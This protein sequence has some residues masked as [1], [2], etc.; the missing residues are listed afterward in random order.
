[1]K[2][3]KVNC[4][5]VLA[6]VIAVALAACLFAGVLLM[7]RGERAEPPISASAALS[8]PAEG[9]SSETSVAFDTANL[10]TEA[11]VKTVYLNM[12]GEVVD[13]ED[14][15]CYIMT[16]TKL[17]DREGYALT[18]FE[19][20]EEGSLIGFTLALDEHTLLGD[21]KIIAIANGVFSEEKVQDLVALDLR[22]TSIEIIGANAFSGQTDL[23]KLDLPE[24]LTH[25]GD[26]AFK[27]VGVKT[28][29]MDPALSVIGDGAFDGAKLVVVRG[30]EALNTVGSEAFAN[31]QLKHF[32]LKSAALGDWGQNVF[33]DNVNIRL[34]HNTSVKGWGRCKGLSADGKWVEDEASVKYPLITDDSRILDF[35]DNIA[36]SS[37]TTQDEYGIKYLL[38]NDGSGFKVTVTGYT[39]SGS[40]LVVPGTVIY[41]VTSENPVVSIG[42]N[43]F[44][45]ANFSKLTA[46]STTEGATIAQ[47][48]F[49]GCNALGSAVIGGG[50]ASLGAGAFSNCSAL[51]SIVL[52]KDVKTIAS[53]AFSGSNGIQT[54]FLKAS[55]DGEAKTVLEG[56]ADAGTQVVAT[57]NGNE[58]VPEKFYTN[59]ILDD[60]NTDKQGVFYKVAEW[61]EQQE[62]VAYVGDTI[63][64]DS[65]DERAF[66]S[67]YGGSDAYTNKRGHVLIPDYISVGDTDEYYRVAVIGRYAFFNCASLQTLELGAHVEQ[68]YDCSLRNCHSLEKFI[69]NGRNS[70]F[71]TNGYSQDRAGQTNEGQ[72]LFAVTHVQDKIT[73]DQIKKASANI[74]EIDPA[75]SATYAREVSSVENYAFANCTGLKS[76]NFQAFTALMYIGEH[77]FENTGLGSVDLTY[78]DASGNPIYVGEEAFSNCYF[79][80]NVTIGKN[81]WFQSVKYVKG[82]KQADESEVNTKVPQY[83]NP[84]LHCTA[85]KAFRSNSETYVAVDDTLYLMKGDYVIL[86]QY[87]AGRKV[88]TNGTEVKKID[89]NNVKYNDKFYPIRSIAAYAFSSTVYLN[90]IAVGENVYI[91][92]KA[93]FENCIRLMNV[94]IGKN[95]IYIGMEIPDVSAE[96]IEGK[97]CTSGKR[98][99]DAIKN[100]YEQEVFQ[101]CYVLGNIKVD[102]E[103]QYYASDTNG[104][105]YN[106]D[107]TELM[108]YGQGISRLTFTVPSTVRKISME[109]FQYNTHI[110]RINLPESVEEIGAK[111][112]NG[113]T[114]LSFIYFRTL[115]A[116]KIG[117]QAFNSAG[118]YNGGLHLYC[119]PEKEA[120]IDGS[121]YSALWEPYFENTERFNSIEEIP[122][123]TQPTN[124]VYLVYVIDADGNSLSD[125]HVEY[126]YETD[127]ALSRN[128]TT[129]NEYGYA[130]LSIPYDL[131]PAMLTQLHV[132]DDA[133]VFFE[134]NMEDYYL[135][136]DIGFTYVTLYAVP[137]A[138]GVTM[139]ATD[140]NGALLYNEN[141]ES[142]TATL[143]TAYLGFL[144]PD[145]LWFEQEIFDMKGKS[146]Q[147]T[148]RGSWDSKTNPT[149]AA[150]YRTEAA[151]RANDTSTSVA[152]FEK[153]YFDNNALYTGTHIFTFTIADLKQFQNGSDELWLR[154][155]LEYG[156]SSNGGTEEI[157]LRL[158][159]KIYY[160]TLVDSAKLNFMSGDLG[161]ELKISKDIPF[162]GGMNISIGK[163]KKQKQFIT[164]TEDKIIM[165]VSLGDSDLE[166]GEL[167]DQ[168]KKEV[169]KNNRSEKLDSLKD[170]ATAI[171]Q[172][173]NSKL[174]SLL[175]ESER[176]A[177]IYMNFGGSI[178]LSCKEVET[179]N[180][181][182]VPILRTAINGAI[183]FQFKWHQ[184]WILL[185]IPVTVNVDASAEGNFE[186]TVTYDY[187][188]ERLFTGNGALVNGDSK[189]EFGLKIK[190][191]VSAGVGCSLASVGLYGSAA[192]DL[193]MEIADEF[194]FTKGI[195]TLDIG[196]YL[197]IDLGLFK[198]SKKWSALDWFGVS[199]EINLLKNQNEASYV[200][201]ED[202]QATRG[203]SFATFHD[204]I[205][206]ALSEVGTSSTFQPCDYTDYSLYG[207]VNPEIVT[208]NNITY[209]FYIENVLLN[210]NSGS[211]IKGNYD[212]YNYLKLVYRY[213]KGN[214]WSDYIIVNDNGR[215]DTDF[216]CLADANG[217]HLIVRS[218]GS[219][220]TENTADT[221][222]SD[223]VL[224]GID[225]KGTASQPILTQSNQEQ[226]LYTAK[227]A[228][229][230]VSGY[231]Y[232]M[233][234]FSYGSTI[235][236]AW[237]GNTDNNVFGM[238]NS[239]TTVED[240]HGATEFQATPTTANYLIVKKAQSNT[241]TE[242]GRVTG[243][244]TVTDG[245]LASLNNRAAFLFIT[246]EDCDITTST[247]EEG[248]P[249]RYV[250]VI[251]LD[252][253]F[254]TAA[255]L[256]GYT[257]S[258]ADG[259]VMTDYMGFSFDG[260]NVYLAADGDLYRLSP[261]NGTLSAELYFEGITGNYRFVYDTNGKLYGILTII[262]EDSMTSNLYFAPYD[263]VN[264]S[265][266][267]FVRITGF[268]EGTMVESYSYY[269]GTDGKLVLS[270]IFSASDLSGGSDTVKF[271]AQDE[272][273]DKPND[274]VFVSAVLEHCE[275]SL[276]PTTSAAAE[277]SITVN[278]TFTVTV[279]NDSI[280]TL[281]SF[282]ILLIDANG[283]TAAETSMNEMLYGGATWSGEVTFTL[284][285][286]KLAL[287]DTYTIKVVALDEDFEELTAQQANNVCLDEEGQ[288]V[289]FA[290]ARPDLAVTADFVVIGGIKYVRLMVQNVGSLPVETGIVYA[291]NGILDYEDAL[292]ASQKEH[293]YVL[294][295]NDLAPGTFRYFTVELNRVWFTEQYVTVGT[296]CLSDD[297]LRNE[298]EWSNN[299]ATIEVEKNEVLEY[300]K[301]T[302]TYYVDEKI[303]HQEYYM[304]GETIS[305]IPKEEM[306]K[307]GYTFEGWVGAS[308]IKMPAH[309]IS[310]YGYYVKN[311][312][313]IKYYIN[314]TLTYQ[315]D[316]EYETVADVR[317]YSPQIGYTFTGW[318][319]EPPMGNSVAPGAKIT[320]TNDIDLYGVT[321][322][323]DYTLYFMVNGRAVHTET[324]HYGERIPNYNYRP[325]EGYEFGG[326]SSYP[327]SMPDHDYYIYGTASPKQYQIEYVIEKEN[328]SSDKI[329]R[330]VL[331]GQEANILLYSR[332]EG[333]VY[334]GWYYSCEDTADPNNGKKIA[335][336]NDLQDGTF[337]M[338]AKSFRL[339]AY[340]HAKEFTVFYIV[341]SECVH[342]EKVAY[343]HTIPAYEYTAPSGVKVSE[344]TNFPDDGMMPA[345][346]LIL[347]GSTE[348][349]LFTIT[350]FKDSEEV[351]RQ[352]VAY[353]AS[354]LFLAAPEK[355][356]YTFTGWALENG[357]GEPVTL[358]DGHMPAYSLVARAQYS[359]NRYQIEWIVDGKTVSTS[360]LEYG[361][362]VTS[363]DYTAPEG[364]TFSGWGTVPATMPAE[365][366]S[367]YGSTS[368]TAYHLTYYI[369]GSSV[370][371]F[372]I[373]YGLPTIS[374]DYVA[375]AG[376]TFNGWQ[377][378]LPAE[379]PAHDI[380]IH[381]TTTVNRY[382]IAYYVDGILIDT[383]SYDYRAA[384]QPYVYQAEIGTT[385]LGFAEEPKTMP[386]HNVNVYGRT[387]RTI[388]H[389]T[390][391]LENETVATE[392][393]PYGAQILPLNGFEREGFT[394]SWGG[395]PLVMP[396]HDITVDGEYIANRYNIRYYCDGELL[397]TDQGVYGEQIRLRA[398]ESKEGYTFTGWKTDATVMPAQ[399][400][401]VYGTF[402]A[403]RYRVTF[404]VNGQ[405]YCNE[406]EFNEEIDLNGL[407]IEGVEGWY[408]DGEK[409][410]TLKM[411]SREIT[412]VAETGSASIYRSAWFIALLSAGI[413]TLLL[414][415]LSVGL[416]LMYKKEKNNK[417]E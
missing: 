152:Y 328:G 108:V 159:V 409:V 231:V 217:I 303:H 52:G 17:K 225:L 21:S 352:S 45:G 410:E 411:P 176:D 236:Y 188:A 95:V 279:K 204:S 89:V 68:I 114:S 244:K 82:K 141:I 75:W 326:W 407:G 315:D 417:Y 390:Y 307:E 12:T 295:F 415:A 99:N 331:F 23:A 370:R 139:T 151:A 343:N 40:E 280:T 53:D 339:T 263:A 190:L 249:D 134:Y 344:W 154:L 194:H 247:N 175:L 218:V 299:G 9:S 195:L 70:A 293:L 376:Y 227:G 304:L 367:F 318:G 233:S 333:Y 274:L 147:I 363:Y 19:R 211:Q 59:F 414:S 62:L 266:G 166:M 51:R 73:F 185:W 329:V 184:T 359:I 397:Y 306:A 29:T 76:F 259:T 179:E 191:E 238:S 314:G 226:V 208:Y 4:F 349:V 235:Y 394:L 148:I 192:L 198:L 341:G 405:T 224:F 371:S 220:L 355:D 401:N 18:A 416:F 368:R 255:T 48:A 77:A 96:D 109:S 178:E 163:G 275:V 252:A 71:A 196:I 395:L 242:V 286:D 181:T 278:A 63:S 28:L 360:T 32:Q 320:V 56:L 31:L 348:D 305:Y 112:F 212:N 281:R 158:N 222:T 122:D 66:T 39:G 33:G 25:I 381:G 389:I 262:F 50:Y 100:V 268:T 317:A 374:Y 246:D 373:L 81:N 313:S 215:N 94:T 199:G 378:T 149:C 93:A 264:R 400:L 2:N 250:R 180:G 167:W 260:T 310:V 239:S 84:F 257:F 309:D 321:A 170:L 271:H 137:S 403:N 216:K 388:Y 118:A 173:H 26:S 210:K 87:P 111:A 296:Y 157:V 90:E 160:Y 387:Q 357:K 46:L 98:D 406:Y 83:R 302:L 273:F 232:N 258:A 294:S 323:I 301:Y 223:I 101:N 346:D 386:A 265:F 129:T 364:Y 207:G 205:A 287:T 203:R 97:I 128:S 37:I 340:E 61:G 102:G 270:Y 65:D 105:L 138:Q 358:T 104:I 107:K 261:A 15:P 54:L 221:Y 241:F 342:E 308:E 384:V 119:I 284:C 272:S 78:A 1:M 132:Y 292:A 413:P 290:V 74:T 47:N 16:F 172:C 356:G 79:L 187:N 219:M 69:V 174:K 251:Y 382:D 11:P 269:W 136:F 171:K 121:D 245:L 5:K 267:K 80:E 214:T 110:Q 316:Y 408:L 230:S 256:Q 332:G 161:A 383:V 92:G 22:N 197:K 243:L 156:D 133:D 377:E 58:R 288:A 3:L 385:F 347:Y 334:D 177:K 201:L 49:A 88:D 311:I 351:G 125:I 330:N 86:L 42:E 153:A 130:V 115:Y 353:G 165:S 325:D 168:M 34:F 103:N 412:L 38:T 338:P 213:R 189:I 106:K 248:A 85:I 379:M 336:L 399:D 366:L 8:A 116:P 169:S 6:A 324:L 43:A 144:N 24:T 143:N 361:A 375:E 91:I 312:Y 206:Y 127:G 319:Y 354:V 164:Y 365:D 285:G 44:Q 297:T 182:G 193:V 209:Q 67:R 10:D 7:R 131:D 282:R 289:L 135:D 126:S 240:S 113:C 228:E 60:K 298:Y 276:T 150:L 72:L 229:K 283:V 391:R 372:E 200:L 277:T 117:E 30:G 369:N 202:E 146:V 345:G 393:Y 162:I 322:Q 234:I 36:Q 362:A 186:W 13:S 14:S 396:A 404:E 392:E 35:T 145:K 41:D 20:K 337:V 57:Q 183:G 291:D 300:N 64:E 327:T 142:T 402:K 380:E 335:S 55:V 253:A 350:Y 123:Q 120:W 140:Q 27:G 155:N 254:P 237:V 124:D 398:S